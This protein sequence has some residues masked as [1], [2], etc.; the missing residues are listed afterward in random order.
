[1]HVHAQA[2]RLVGLSDGVREGRQNVLLYFFS[3][4]S[5]E[6]SAVALSLDD[7]RELHAALGVMLPELMRSQ[8]NLAELN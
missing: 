2:A 4:G 7:A 1:M 5:E 6:P 8:T 3:R